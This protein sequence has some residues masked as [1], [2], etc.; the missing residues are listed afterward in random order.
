MA[1]PYATEDTFSLLKAVRDLNAMRPDI[2]VEEEPAFGS[3]PAELVVH[4]PLSD[5]DVEFYEGLKRL[6]A[7]A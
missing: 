1:Q 6:F 5:A 2:H 3:L 7:P 4:I